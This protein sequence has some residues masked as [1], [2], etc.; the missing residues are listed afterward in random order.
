MTLLKSVT[1]SRSRKRNR[2]RW[3]SRIWSYEEKI[4]RIE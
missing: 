4:F 1:I 3:T 2:F